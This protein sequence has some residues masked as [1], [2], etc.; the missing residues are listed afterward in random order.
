MTT[1]NE[2]DNL[3]K[4]AIR[5]L[6]STLTLE[7]TPEILEETGWIL[8]VYLKHY[9]ALRKEYSTQELIT[10]IKQKKVEHEEQLMHLIQELE[11]LK[12]KTNNPNRKRVLQFNTNIITFIKKQVVD[13]HETNKK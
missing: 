5:K 6:L 7:G 13:T 4:T 8:K 9:Y 1:E 3:Q 2:E 10:R 12:Y 11:Y